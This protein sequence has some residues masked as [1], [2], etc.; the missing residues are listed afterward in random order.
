MELFSKGFEKEEFETLHSAVVAARHRSGAQLLEQ[1]KEA[2]G[3]Y[4]IGAGADNNYGV[5][6]KQNRAA[7]TLGK[8]SVWEA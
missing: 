4:H 1:P 8:A 7:F 2:Q 6:D 5:K 3:N